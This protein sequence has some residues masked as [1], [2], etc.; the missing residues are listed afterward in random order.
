MTSM[1]TTAIASR[2]DLGWRPDLR[3]PLV[4]ALV[5]LLGLQLFLALG[6]SLRE[7]GMAALTAQTPLLAFTPADV[8]R[9][10][11]EGADGN[12]GVT[13]SRTPQGS[14]VLA[15][16]ADF[17]VQPAKVDQLLTQLAG[18]KRPLPIATSEEA[19]KRFKLAD[20]GFE[21]RLT[22]EGKDGAVAT[23]LIGDSPGFRRI[24]ARPAD[25]PSV[26]DLNL[27][28]SDLSDRRDDWLD[29]GLLR[30]EPGQIVRIAGKDWA[31]SK[32]ADLWRLDNNEQSVDQAAANALA[33]QLTNLSYRG[34]LGTEDAPAYRQQEPT[35]V[36]T[37]GLKD[38]NARTYRISQAENSEDY[39]LKDAER[40]YFFKLSGYDLEGLL[41]LEPAKL[42]VK[43]A[44]TNDPPGVEQ[45]E[46]APPVETENP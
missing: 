16:L 14:W 29:T 11:V 41:D 43:S 33:M 32:D 24:F 38:G 27:A 40:P 35:L 23:L 6:L 12:G 3:S 31:L 9:V 10:R 18:L 21:R 4:I 2:A 42:T 34:V 30:L 20:D 26:Y 22:L 8:T 28:L 36:L 44:S 7:P 13:L 25:D 5:L 45:P 46:S 19:R 37:I 15:D 1:K 39:V 17:P